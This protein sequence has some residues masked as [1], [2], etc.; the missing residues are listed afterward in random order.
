M[1]CEELDT[2]LEKVCLD[3]AILITPSCQTTFD[4]KVDHRLTRNSPGYPAT[5]VQIMALCQVYFLEDLGP[6]RP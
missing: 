4:G 2:G 1:Q 3:T 6:Q 5:L